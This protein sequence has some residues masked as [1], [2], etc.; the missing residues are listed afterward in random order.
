[1]TPIIKDLIKREPI[2]IKGNSKI[3]DA[4]KLM[5]KNNVGSIVLI[6]DDGKAIGIFT[7]RD[8]LRA[9][10]RGVSLEDPVEKVATTSNLVKLNENEKV[11]RAAME[12][13]KRGIRHIIVEDEK[14]KLK[15]VIS[16]RDIIF[17]NQVLKAIALIGE[18]NVEGS[19]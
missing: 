19:D 17:E 18:N 15:G 14:G 8:L 13:A 11:S 9:I 4:V 7:E 2:V 3:K 5:E 12:M 16:M 10:A 6:N 1:M